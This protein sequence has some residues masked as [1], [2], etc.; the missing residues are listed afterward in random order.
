MNLEKKENTGL[1]H[2]IE[3][4]KIEE[5]VEAIQEEIR[6]DSEIVELTRESPTRLEYAG[7]LEV[8]NEDQYN[9]ANEFILKCKATLKKIDKGKLDDLCKKGNAIHKGMTTMKNEFSNPLY[10]AVKIATK[11]TDDWYRE[12]LRKS[13]EKQARIDAEARDRE[14]KQKAKDEERARKAREKGNIEKAEL[15]EEQAETHRE[16]VPIIDT[17]SEKLK[18]SFGSMT[19]KEVLSATITNSEDFIKYALEKN[20][21]MINFIEININMLSKYINDYKPGKEGIPG[22]K[23]TTELKTIARTK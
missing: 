16:A 6:N 9:Q 12:E 21:T 11:K 4:A 14:R 10:E 13:R 7:K 20:A 5:V 23:I 2:Y 15:I 19:K 17:P 1:K 8:T 22:V 3:E 18:T